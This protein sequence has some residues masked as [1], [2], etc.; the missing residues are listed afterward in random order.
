MR[1]AAQSTIRVSDPL[2]LGDVSLAPAALTG[3]PEA[4]LARS[5]VEQLQSADPATS[6]EAVRFLRR[7][8]PHSPLTVRVAALA[9]LMRR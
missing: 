2:P 4:Q 6:A 8:F 9:A 3:I 7:A 5:M 1:A